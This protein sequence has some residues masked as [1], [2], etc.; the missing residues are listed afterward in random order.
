MLITKF[1]YNII[2]IYFLFLLVVKHGRY[3]DMSSDT[4]L[5]NLF[6]PTINK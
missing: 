4:A 6:F 2:T 3:G 5:S 1:D